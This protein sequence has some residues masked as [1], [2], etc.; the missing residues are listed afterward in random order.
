MSANGG[1]STLAEALDS[2]LVLLSRGFT[3]PMPV[4]LVVHLT[5][6]LLK[7][8]RN[9]LICWS[10]P[11]WITV[12]GATEEEGALGLSDPQRLSIVVADKADKMFC[13]E[14]LS[15]RTYTANHTHSLRYRDML[16]CAVRLILF[17]SG[18]FQLFSLQPAKEWNSA[19]A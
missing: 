15:G 11:V 9:K 17:S 7:H 19:H 2:L 14:W 3:W 12:Q 6:V 13:A 1:S 10:G 5:R 16:A 4:L 8:K 18:G